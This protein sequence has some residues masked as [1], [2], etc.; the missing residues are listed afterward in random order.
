MSKTDDIP[1]RGPLPDDDGKRWVADNELTQAIL[2]GINAKGGASPEP[3]RK[4]IAKRMKD[5]R[6]AARYAAAGFK[7]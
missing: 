4:L 2:D 1:R 7:A 3:V 5:P 6:F